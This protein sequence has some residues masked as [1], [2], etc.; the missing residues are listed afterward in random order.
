[1]SQLSSTEKPFCFLGSTEEK[2]SVADSLLCFLNDWST[3][4]LWSDT[5]FGASDTAIETIE[6]AFQRYDFSVFILT[7]DDEVISRENRAYVPRDNIIFEIGLSIATIGRKNTIL[8]KDKS[9][10]L[11]LPSDF[12]NLTHFEYDPSSN[13]IDSSMRSISGKIRSHF[14]KSK[15][16]LIATARLSRLNSS[17]SEYDRL[18]FEK[19]LN[20]FI[21]STYGH[22]VIR[23][24]WEVKIDFD[25]SKTSLGIISEHME[26]K[27][28]LS[29]IT[30]SSINYPMLFKGYQD[31][32]SGIRAIKSYS[33]SSRWEVIDFDEVI[34]ESESDSKIISK[35]SE[36]TIDPKDELEVSFHYCLVHKINTDSPLTHNVL[37]CREACSAFELSVLVPKEY[38]LELV[39]LSDCK[40]EPTELAQRKVY[41]WG[42]PLLPY[43]AIEYIL[44]K[45]AT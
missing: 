34:D 22:K 33:N 9:A 40:V 7:A 13:A 17:V 6:S 35:S 31:E 37:F 27:Y 25:T 12:S 8:I 18:D 36:V 30:D 5:V 10:I 11:K 26:F 45:K 15:N 2:L 19:F 41:R 32:Y 38:S 29:N 14:E 20:R 1:M 43:H 42:I 24:K 3:T 44:S 39:Q 4:E 16:K 21:D 23:K 28:V